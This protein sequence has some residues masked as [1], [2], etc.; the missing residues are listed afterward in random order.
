M[1]NPDLKN[2]FTRFKVSGTWLDGT[3]AGSGLIH[4]TYLIHTA[5]AEEPD[6]ILQKINNQVFP[7]VTEMMD[8]IQKVTDHIRSKKMSDGEQRFL[9]VIRTHS[10]KT[11][12]I[13]SEGCYW[14]MFKKIE[15]GISY[16][17]VTNEN[18][19]REAGRAF[20]QFI[21][22]LK[23]FPVDA[24]FP[25]LPDFHSIELRYE[26]LRKAIQRN[27]L[28]RDKVSEDEIN[29]AHAQID[30]MLV[31]PRLQ[32]EG[33][34][35]VRVTHNDTKLN[36]ILFDEH[37]KAV[38][39]I[40]LDTVMPGLTLYDFGDTIRSAANTAAEDEEYL[41]NIQFS[42]P[43][44][45]AYTEGFL[46]TTVSFLTTSELENLALSP[47]Y[48]TFIMGVRFLTDYISGDVYYQTHYDDQ[49]LRRCRAQFQLMK[50]MIEMHAQC[51]DMVLRIAAKRRGP[52]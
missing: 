10:D 28:G 46:D 36:N 43:V 11:F 13:D 6:Y 37:E 35:P 34:L 40:D 32:K 2:L 5:E 23:D 7:C 47:Q 24:L 22:D 29:F 19:A 27:P 41:E 26:Q 14:R 9:E 4:V 51:Q 16:D 48:M 52:T 1:R 30:R 49:N 44:F 33:A 39:V 17:V 38:S 15:P 12:F 3:P 21:A 25:V 31:V 45:E 50:R 8:N 42:I 18:I 20:G